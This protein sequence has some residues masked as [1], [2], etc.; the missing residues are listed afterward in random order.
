[1]EE[2]RNFEM[3]Q[4]YK[5]MNSN[6]EH[7]WVKS[8]RKN[9]DVSDNISLVLVNTYDNYRIRNPNALSVLPHEY[10]IA[11]QKSVTDKKFGPSGLNANAIIG[12]NTSKGITSYQRPIEIPKQH[13]ILGK[14]TNNY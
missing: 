13:K 3:G 2:T 7:S 6:M 4:G 11:K 1:M 10:I 12:Y 9:V 8:N 5:T 14:Y